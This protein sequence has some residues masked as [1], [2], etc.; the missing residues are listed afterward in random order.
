MTIQLEKHLPKVLEHCHE[1]KGGIL[2]NEWALR[3]KEHR[4][5]GRG[6]EDIKR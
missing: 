3:R 5:Y 4:T 2:K 1:T 6:D